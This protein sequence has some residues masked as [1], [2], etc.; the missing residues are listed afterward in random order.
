M[1]LEEQVSVRL[2]AKGRIQAVER[3]MTARFMLA[4]FAEEAIRERER[5]TEASDAQ[6]CA[7]LA[8]ID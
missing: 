8:A 2:T 3:I 6:L 5:L 1:K 7:E 4:A